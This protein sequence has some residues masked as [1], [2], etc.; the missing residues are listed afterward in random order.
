MILQRTDKYVHDIHVMFPSDGTAY[1]MGQQPKTR[2]IYS[3]AKSTHN[4]GATLVQLKLAP[5]CS[6]MYLAAAVVRD[7]GVRVSAHVR[8]LVL[9]RYYRLYKFRRHASVRVCHRVSY[10][11]NGRVDD[12]K[13]VQIL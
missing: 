2:N 6:D 7:T 11:I 12:Y 10:Q 5:L 9:F 8:T 3:R 4:A 13:M 1:L